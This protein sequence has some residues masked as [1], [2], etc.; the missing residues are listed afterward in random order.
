ME[1][2]KILDFIRTG[3]TDKAIDLF[4]DELIASGGASASTLKAVRLIEAEYNRLREDQL[5]NTIDSGTAEAR[6]NA[7]NKRLLDLLDSPSALQRSAPNKMALQI[8]ATSVGGLL[9]PFL[10]W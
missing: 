4:L 9:L 8:G 7:I 2:E 5:Q 10:A 1:K 6:L 3:D